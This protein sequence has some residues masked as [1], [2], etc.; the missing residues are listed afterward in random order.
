MIKQNESKIPL[1]EVK[2]FALSF[3][4][5]EKGLR[6]KELKVIESLNL[7]VNKGEIVAIVGASGSGKSLLA[8]AILG[9]LPDDAICTGEL[10]YKGNKLTNERL[11][12][13]RGREIFLIPQSVNSLDPLMKVGKQ[14]Q[15]IIDDRQKQ[16]IQR[17]IFKRVGLKAEVADQFPF[18]LSGG[19]ARRVLVAGAM[20][21][22]AELIIADEPTPGL[23]PEVL[24]ETMRLIKQLARADKGI[25]LIS[26]DINTALKVADKVVVFQAGETIEEAPIAAF[27]GKG[28]QLQHPFTKKL[29]NAL[30]TNQFFQSKPN[31]TRSSNH[32]QRSNQL[33]EIKDLSYR[34]GKNPYLFKGLNL[35]VQSGEVVG[36]HGYSGS[37][38]TTMAQVIAGYLKPIAGR[39]QINQQSIPDSGLHPIQ[40]VWQHPEKAINPYWRMHQVL[41]ESHMTNHQLLDELGIKANWLHRKPSDLSG[42]ELQRFCIARSLHSELKFLIADEMTTMLD[43]VT[44]AKLWQIILRLVKEENL[45]VIAISH[46]LSLLERISD[47]IYHFSDLSQLS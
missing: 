21:S 11:N 32:C 16:K 23:D 14:V 45:G 12:K 33:L 42:G 30:P 43:A 36:I 18:E 26:H 29:W 38:K 6:E 20:V 5:I 47:R 28:E 37:G 1:L 15:A 25:L 2:H 13:L 4:T 34:Y 44:Q 35:T 8:N 31:Q 19:M 39:I 10:K 41:A 40:L 7:T 24:T 3:K 9:I 17:D 27:T 22:S 46:D